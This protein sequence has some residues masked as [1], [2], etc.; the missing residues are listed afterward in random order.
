MLGHLFVL[1][2]GGRERDS[3]KVDYLP[4]GGKL[5]AD[6]G[7]TETTGKTQVL[8][9]IFEAS[10]FFHDLLVRPQCFHVSPS[11][12]NIPCEQVPGLQQDEI[13]SSPRGLKQDEIS[14]SPRGLKLSRLFYLSSFLP[15]LSYFHYKQNGR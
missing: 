14:S 6:A 8:V 1:R 7:K 3:G 4:L 2:E 10:A 15:L 9:S 5:E 11:G 13:T 12:S